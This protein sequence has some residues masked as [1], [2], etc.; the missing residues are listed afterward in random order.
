MNSKLVLAVVVILLLLYVIFK[1]LTT[2][3]ATLGTMQ[4]SKNETTLSG[5]NLPRSIKVN[6]AVSVWFY[7]KEWVGDA[8]IIR[9]KNASSASSDIMSVTLH[10]TR[11]DIIIKPRSNT[12]SGKTCDISEFPL[13]KWVNLII[14]FNGAAMDVYLDGKLVKSCVVDRGSQLNET[15]SIILGD[16]TAKDFGFIT[17]VKLKANPIPPQEAWDIYSQGYGGSPWSDLLNKYKLKLSFMV[18]N[19]EQVTVST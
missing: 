8:N 18:D 1:A 11:N 4:P 19:Q 3:Y 15:I 5:D 2:S 13:Q 17:N 9:F 12:A 10:A 6:S 14:S 7:L 16:S